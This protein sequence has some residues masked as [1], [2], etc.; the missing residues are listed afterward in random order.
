MELRITNWQNSTPP[1]EA[2]LRQIYRNEG[3]SPFAWS[4]APGDSYASHTHSYDKVI[5]VL[6]GSITWILPDLDRRIDTRAGD[7]VDLPKGT[8]HAAE[9]GPHGVTCLEAHAG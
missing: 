3:L 2:E 6:R 4:N 9:V 5:F 8:R 7:R 1:T